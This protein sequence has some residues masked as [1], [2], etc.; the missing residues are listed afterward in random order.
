MHITIGLVFSFIVPLVAIGDSNESVS[1]NDNIKADIEGLSFLEGR[2]V[3]EIQ[4][5][6]LE[7]VWSSPAGGTIIG[8]FRW[9]KKGKV[10]L[11]ESFAIAEGDGG[12][13]M[14]FRH[15]DA[16]FSCWEEKDKPLTF[17]LAHL[18][19]NE[20]LFEHVGEGDAWFIRYR[21]ADE[22]SLTVTLE[23]AKGSKRKKTEFQYKRAKQK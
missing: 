19:K 21:L 3:T 6:S 16:K 23:G 8:M 9:I 1:K 18:T 15:F 4:G 17:K 5:D 2:W 7:E 14:W 10:W 11:Y 22:N 12:I 20:A 13:T